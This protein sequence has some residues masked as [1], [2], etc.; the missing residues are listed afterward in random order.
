MNTYL[1]QL[2]E[3]AF[4]VN[5]QYTLTLVRKTVRE[6]EQYIKQMYPA[7]TKIVSIKVTL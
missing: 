6:C 3:T 4:V 7:G 2:V 1:I 5:A